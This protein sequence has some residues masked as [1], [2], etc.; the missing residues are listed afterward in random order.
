MRRIVMAFMGTVSGLVLLF[1]YHTSRNESAAVTAERPASSSTGSTGTTGSGTGSGSG[2]SGQG[3]YSGDTVQTR[4]GPVQ[5]QIVVANGTIVSSTTLQ[6]P[7]ENRRDQE[8]NSYA[9]PIL[10]AETVDAQSAN[11]DSVSGATITSEGYKASLQSAI[12]QAQL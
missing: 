4:W 6:V 10:D 5:V 12:D 2:A 7:S 3:T 1:S 11:I 9:V 8:I